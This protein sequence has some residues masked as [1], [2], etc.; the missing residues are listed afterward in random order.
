M[1]DPLH[2]LTDWNLEA[3]TTLSLRREPACF[4]FLCGEADAAPQ[5]IDALN[6]DLASIDY[7]AGRAS[8]WATLE[9]RSAASNNRRW[10]CWASMTH[11]CARSRAR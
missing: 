6:L 4:A 7:Y 10:R 8:L 11:S 2:A 1:Q 5:P 3:A 9:I